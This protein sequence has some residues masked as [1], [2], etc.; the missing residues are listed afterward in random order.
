MRQAPPPQPVSLAGR[1]ILAGILLLTLLPT[2]AIAQEVEPH[3]L[4]R[5]FGEGG[6]R[7]WVEDV[8]GEVTRPLFWFGMG[9]QAMF[10]MRFVWQWIVSERRGHSTVPIA[11]WYFSLVGGAAMFIYAVLK[12]DPV[13]MSGQALAV[14]IYTRNLMLIY[15]QAERRKESGMRVGK[16]RSEVEGEENNHDQS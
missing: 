14:V 15:R 2:L 5:F 7:G 13:I 11:F 12:R 10:F 3:W 1:R 9:A 16:L 8:W 4:D 6:I